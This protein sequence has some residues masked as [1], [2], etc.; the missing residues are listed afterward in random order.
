MIGLQFE[1]GDSFC[2]IMVDGLSV[3]WG[4]QDGKVAPMDSLHVIQDVLKGALVGLESWAADVNDLRLEEIDFQTNRSEAGN[5][6]L[7]I[8]Y[9]WKTRPVDSCVVKDQY[10]DYY[11]YYYYNIIIIIVI[12]IFLNFLRLL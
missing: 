12:T 4:S 5:E 10:Y 11:Y 7:E 9:H 6:A 2:K 8:I 1:F 3:N